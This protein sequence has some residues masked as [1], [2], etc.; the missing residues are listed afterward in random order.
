VRAEAARAGGG[1]WA[2]WATEHAAGLPHEGERAAAC[3]C[4]RATARAG[5]AARVGLLRSVG[6]D[7]GGLGGI[8]FR[9]L[10]VL[11]FF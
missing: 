3:C 1:C 11:G 4:G 9:N 6:L 8:G 2:S 10:R 7:G 5:G